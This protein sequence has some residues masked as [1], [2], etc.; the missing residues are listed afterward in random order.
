[1]PS[2]G[3]GVGTPIVGGAPGTGF[4]STFLRPR[5]YLSLEA[6]AQWLGIA[7]SAI[8]GIV[9]QDDPE[10]GCDDFYFDE[11]NRVQL[12]RAIQ[13]AEQALSIHLKFPLLRQ[14]FCDEIYTYRGCET[15]VR[16]GR[17]LA[18][19]D[20]TEELVALNVATGVAALAEEY[21]LTT[22]V[23]FPDCKQL[24][25]YYPGQTRWEIIPSKVTISG[26]T[27]SITI[28]RS[29]L[30][31]PEY[32]KDF[33]QADLSLRP[34]FETS[35]YFLPVVDVYRRY[36]DGAQSVTFIWRRKRCW[37][38]QQVCLHAETHPGDVVTQTGHG[39][40][41]DARLGIIQIEPAEFNTV[42]G[43]FDEKTWVEC[44]EPDGFTINYLA[45]I[46]QDCSGNCPDDV[47]PEITRAIIALAHSN[48]P[49]GLCSC[50]PA[51]VYYEMDSFTP[52]PEEG[53]TIFSP[54]GTTRGQNTAWQIVRRNAQGFGGL[55]G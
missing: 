25:V 11:S 13:Q 22:T 40:I 53:P 43:V 16:N 14:Y 39:V 31:K 17:V 5:T 33:N 3:S 21:V 38:G 30:L 20:K 49:K 52:R 35:S 6:Y 1:V 46:D 12:V 32:L 37:C 51:K 8:F 48:M 28:P 36:P 54:F 29:R 2:S 18:L 47:D 27:A 26:T 23:A 50:G 44:R 42:T 7:E 4:V 41:V 9:R 15:Q 55:L 34:Q 10:Y 19:G 45:G 24:V